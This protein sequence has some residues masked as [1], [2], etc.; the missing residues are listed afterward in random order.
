MKRAL[1]LVTALLLAYPAA[2]AT[3]ATQCYRPT[4][5][6]AEQAIRYQAEL[7]VLADSCGTEQTYV[8]WTTRLRRVLVGYQKELIAHFR[9]VGTGHA[10]AAFDSYL[11][12]LANEASLRTGQTPIAAACQQAADFLAKADRF[13]E[14]DF[15]QYVVAQAVERKP[16]YKICGK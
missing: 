6:E 4:E 14:E 16:D 2:S 8:S 5:I 3:A 9:R 7:M 1:L 15:R 10:E 12:K 13:G 11:T